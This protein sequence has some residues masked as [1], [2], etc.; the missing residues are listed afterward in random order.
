MKPVLEETDV[1]ADN[2]GRVEIAGT[3]AR[4]S[5]AWFP[6]GGYRVGA[7]A[8]A[9]L[10]EADLDSTRDGALARDVS[11]RGYA[12]GVEVGRRLELG[13]V[14]LT[15]RAGADWSMVELSSFTDSLNERVSLDAGRRIA[16]RA[17]VRAESGALGGGGGVFAT[18]DVERELSGAMRATAA[19]RAFETDAEATWARF[20]LGAAHEWAG[21]RVALR[22][23]ANYAAAR[24]GNR[25]FSG[26]AT[27][28][29]RF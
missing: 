5:G 21:G 27:L 23:A 11:G 17:G 26:S 16:A 3:G 29:V 6:G 28:T 13:R 15:P 22:A 8:V 19:K 18:L 1:G 25:D 9:T 7:Q 10:Y 2:G 4:I 14:T 24:R 12:A 20:G